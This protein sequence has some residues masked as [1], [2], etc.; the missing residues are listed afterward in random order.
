MSQCFSNRSPV[1]MWP[2]SDVLCLLNGT[3]AVDISVTV[4]GFIVS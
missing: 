2:S 4:Y 3:M 1:A